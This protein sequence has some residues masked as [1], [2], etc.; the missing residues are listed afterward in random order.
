MHILLLLFY[1]YIIMQTNMSSFKK[2]C[3]VLNTDYY[4]ALNNIF[5]FYSDQEQF[6]SNE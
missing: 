1:V 5:V 4:L 2:T 6:A 3:M